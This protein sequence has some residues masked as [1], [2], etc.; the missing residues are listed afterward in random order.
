MLRNY[1]LLIVRNLKRQKLFS[2]INLIG[3]TAGI[4]SSLIIY[5][6]VINDFT[7]DRFHAH[8]DRIYRVNQTNISG[9]NDGKQ[10]ARTAPG[11]ATALNAALPEAEFITSIYSVDNSI[12]SHTD[13]LKGLV[14]YDQE[15]IRAVDAN[16]FRVFSFEVVKGNALTSLLEPN[17]IAVTESTA[18]KYF[19]DNEPLGKI[20]EMGVGE[21][22][23][24]FEVKA[25]VK[26]VS[27]DSYIRFEILMSTSA[28]PRIK[29]RADSWV[30]TQLEIFI[31]LNDK[32]D[33]TTAREKLKPIP[34]QYAEASLRGAMNMGFDD[35]L[36][37]GKSWELYLQP[38]T[39]IY[40]HSENVVGNSSVI[41]NLKISYTLVGVALFV[42]LLSC[43]NFI[44]LST[45]QFTRRVKE[46]SIRKI[47]GLSRK[48][49][50]VHYFF[51]AFAF[52]LFALVLALCLMQ[53][54]LPFFNYAT[55]KHLEL[56][57]AFNSGL[58][59]TIV[60]LLVLMSAVSGS[61][62]ALFLSA[63]SPVEGIKGK[64]KTGREGKGFRNALVIVQFSV[65]IVLI[66]CTT[67]VFQQLNYF[68]EKNLGFDKENLVVLEHVERVDNAEALTLGVSRM[69]GVVSTSFCTALPM[70][71]GNDVFR[72]EN[73][74]D[75][76]FK[77]H[78]ASGDERY[79]S[80]L[81]AKLM[82]GR[83]FS[84]D[85]PAEVDKVLLNETA[86]RTLGWKMD[87]TVIGKII[88]YPN[89]STKFEVAGVV[90]DF[91]FTSLETAIQP[92][93]IFHIRSKV[94]N[95]RKFV[96]VRL[97]AGQ[98]KLWQ[99]T[100]LVLKNVWKEYAGDLPFQYKFIDQTFAAQ[101]EGHQQFGR[102]LKIMAALAILIAC[103]GLLG[104]VVYSL[105]QRTKE[106]GIRKIS[107]ASVINIVTLISKGY[108]R[109]IIIS[110]VIS[111]P[112]SYWLI[113]QWLQDFENR[114]TPSMWV[115]AF[116]GVATLLF[117]FLI[118]SYHSVSA[119]QANPVDVLKDE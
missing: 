40:L 32:A 13:K 118:T 61:F 75:K 80:T 107:G 17:G 89:E 33:I 47:L 87:E 77:L 37:K 31:L 110:F 117:S 99:S 56:N 109:L 113:G 86:V 90:Q 25:V 76:D 65:S 53:V 36:K 12:V 9:D 67:I 30:W 79:L 10:L 70:Q 58:W 82:I 23:R 4:V 95:Q 114:I 104:M 51:E 34:R 3:L 105:E 1:F 11:V 59:M 64:L 92:M 115:Y 101:L 28:F 42:I 88:D 73:H 54:L 100:S 39:D 43:I 102:S 57:A 83:N 55:G 97:A 8:A 62:P 63:F 85:N 112:V 66:I 7:H 20:L 60:S 68:A 96:L 41:G 35:Y 108:T 48:E 52:C 93:A 71:M 21:N 106:I 5:L 24:P 78:F 44:N 119:A 103:L 15:N 84:A 26:D 29:E 98:V 46:A 14:T 49:L 6:Y 91:H 74:G 22:K 116:T 2:I 45:A 38:I 69:P 50:S 72:P 18:K 16:F 94:F 27:D 81:G 111:A 19:G